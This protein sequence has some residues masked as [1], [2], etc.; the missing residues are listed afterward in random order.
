MSW[1][2]RDPVLDKETTDEIDRAEDRAA[3][4]LAGAYFEDR[5][6]IVIKARLLDDASVANPLFT[7][8]GPLGTFSAKIDMAYL[9]RVFD[10]YARSSLHVIRRI[11]NTFAHGLSPLTFDS[12]PIKAKC[13]ALFRVPEL[14]LVANTLET[15]EAYRWIAEIVPLFLT[16]LTQAP[17]TPRNAYMNTL[18][19]LL[20]LIELN[21][22]VIRYRNASPEW[23]GIPS[24]PCPSG[25]Q[26]SGHT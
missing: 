26:S 9:L 4:V 22:H 2:H 11:R 7:G 6:T 25:S 14:T 1:I 20:A 3:A 21:Q 8:Y 23:K 5:L 17:D 18:R 19:Y 12:P 10:S 16:P 15:D 24:P 13:E